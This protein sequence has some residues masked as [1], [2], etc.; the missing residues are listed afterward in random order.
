MPKKAG[1]SG[2]APHTTRRM[3]TIV[4]AQKNGVA[5]IGADTMSCLGSLRQRAHHVVNK[6]KI[7]KIGDTFIGLTGTSASLVVMNS[8]FANPERPRDFSSTDMIFET[9]RH[10]HHWMKTEYFMSTMASKEEE[11][12]TT[13]FYGVLA[14]PHGIF[15][16]YSYRSAQQFHKFW[17][18]GSGRDFALGAMQMVYDPFDNVVDIVRAGLNAAAEFDSA[19]GAPYEIHTCALNS[20]PQAARKPKKRA[21]AR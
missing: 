11:Y 21:K 7:T 14:N 16:L 9:F 8:Y 19:T 13:Q 12:E 17:A 6:T 4:I 18:A 20:A 3:S 1:A 15:A 10:A 5:C 2:P